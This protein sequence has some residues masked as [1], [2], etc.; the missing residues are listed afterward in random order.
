MKRTLTFAT[1][2]ALGAAAAF[3]LPS[4]AQASYS[5]VISSAPPEPLYERAPGHRRG[6]VWTPGYW[7]WRGHRHEWVGGHWVAERPGYAYVAPAWHQRHGGWYLEPGRWQP[8]HAQQYYGHDRGY[9]D[10]R[11]AEHE[12]WQARRDHE[13]WVRRNDQDRDGIPNRYDR[14]RDGDGVP[15]HHDRDRDGDG[16]P[17]RYDRDPDSWRRR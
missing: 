9:Q 16:V 10:W 15:N 5:I 12:Q 4:M 13:R 3:P 11:R 2:L 14:D 6:Y 17:N 8:Y 1:L 7:D